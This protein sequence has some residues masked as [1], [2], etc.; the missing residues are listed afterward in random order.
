MTL[1]EI[2][3]NDANHFVAMEYYKL[4]LNRTFII[5]ITED[6][7]IGLLGNGT[8]S[9]EGGKDIL[10]KQISKQFAIRG[11]LSN[12]YSYLKE[13]YI[14]EIENDNI[15]SEKI[16]LKNKMNFVINR[17]DIKDVNYNPKKKFGMG[18]YPHDGRV[19]IETN[20]GKKRELIILGNQSGIEIADIIRKK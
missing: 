6:K 16:L 1:K 11:D 15:N 19:T 17:K 20:D 13:K 8:I 5:L 2:E 3:L 4:I 12:P 7:I 14:N 10:T 18:Y 9:V